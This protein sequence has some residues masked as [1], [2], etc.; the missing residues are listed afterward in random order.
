VAKKKAAVVDSSL[1]KAWIDNDHAELSISKQ[2]GLLSLPRSSLYYEK[3]PVDLCDLK[4]MRLIDRQ[5]L[6]TPFYGSRR[7][8]VAL[9]Q[10]GHAIGREKT[11]SLMRTMGIEAIYPKPNLSKRNTN[12]KIYPYL[13][14]NLNITRVN[15]VWSTD[16]TYLPLE[17]GFAFLVAVIDWFSRYILSWRISSTLE[18][19]F[20]IEALEAALKVG[21]PEIFNTDQGCQFTSKDFTNILLQK[22]IQISMD[23]KGRALDNIIIERLWRSYKYEDLYINGYRTIQEVKQ[24]TKAYMNFYSHERPHQSL[25]YKTPYSVFTS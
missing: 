3:A 14:R 10:L 4:L 22:K 12:H 13:L 11:R 5:Y 16:I 21:T 25:E 8:T 9:N 17:D 2:C 19:T 24:G 1:K 20:C 18:S 15:Q 7:M 23:S 6:R